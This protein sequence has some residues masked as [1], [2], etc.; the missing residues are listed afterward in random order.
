MVIKNPSE[1]PPDHPLASEYGGVSGL[2]QP[3]PHDVQDHPCEMLWQIYASDPAVGYIDGIN[4]IDEQNI[5]TTDPV[6]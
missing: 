2:I 6:K 3:E 4:P 1:F 5:P